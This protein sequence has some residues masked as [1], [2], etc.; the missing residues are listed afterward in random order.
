MPYSATGAYSK[1]WR[2]RWVSIPRCA[3]NARQF[4]RLVHLPTSVTR[5]LLNVFYSMY[6]REKINPPEVRGGGFIFG[7]LSCMTSIS[8]TMP[9]HDLALPKPN[10]TQRYWTIPLHHIAPSHLTNT[11][12]D[13]T[14]LSCTI[15]TLCFASALPGITTLSSPA[16]HDTAHYFSI[17]ILHNS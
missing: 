8:N 2:T 17:P 1:Y 7:W 15:A 4:S 14:G 3:T 5:P 16:Q 6:L 10:E 11:W 13:T 12:P 9:K